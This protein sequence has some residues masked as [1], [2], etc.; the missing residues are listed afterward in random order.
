M[1]MP[2]ALLVL[3]LA[4]SPGLVVHGQDDT[5]GFI[6][7]DCGIAEGTAYA[8]QPTHGLRYVSDAGF[9]DAG[10]GLNAAINP[11]YNV[12]GTSTRY[13]T[14]R[15]FP[16]A[17]R[18]CYTLR[19]GVT[20]GG[21]YLVRATFYY[22]NY[23]GLNRLPVFD[24]HL[25]VNRWVTVNVTAPGA[26]YI[27][28]AVV[29]PPADFFQVCLVNRGL[30][31]PFISGL[32]LRPLQ[33]DMYP[34]ATLNQSLALLNFRRP[35][36]TYILNRYH[37][38]RPA[39]TYAL[40][41]YPFD[42]YDRLWQA[43]GDIDAW[44]NITRP[45]DVSNI[46]SFH[47]LP[48]ILWSAATPVNGTQI[49]FAWSS[50]SSINNDNTSYLLLLYFEEVQRLPSNAVRRFDILVDNSTWNGSQRYSP[51][52]LSSE[53]VKRMVLG[54]RQHTV[55][56]VATPDATLP[57]I[58][59][60]F[61]IYSV[62]PM[63]ELATNGA[64]AKAMMAIRTKYALKKNWMGD[65]CA[66]KA[67]AW[68]GL[69]C[70]NFSSG[71]AWITA[72][73]LSSSGLSGGIDASFGNLK[74][75]QWLDLSNNSLSGPVPDFL[76]QMPS[77]T[78]L[79]L[80]SNKL[81]GPVP[82]VLL[83][84]HQNG[85]LVLRIGN[86]ANI[87]DNGAST[88]EPE[89][90]NG[91]R[92]LA[93]A[94]VVPIAVATLLFVAALILHRLKHKQVTWTANNSRL[95][96]PQERSTAFGNRQFTYKE[97]KRMTA[98]FEE[99]I[100]RG[101]FGAVFLGYLENGSPVA[102]KMCTKTS[103]GDKAFSA[104]AQHLTRVHHRNLV[105]LI[106]YCKD[107]KHLALVY[108]YMQGGNLENRLR[109]QVSAITPLTWHQRLKIALDSAHGLEYLHKA[110]QP[111]LIHRDVK[112]TNILLSADLEAKISDFGL[113]KVFANDFDTHITTQPAGTL[114][115]LDPEYYNTSRLSE[116]SDVYSFGV[117]LLELIT[118]Q[119]PAVTITSTDRIHIALWVRQKL[120]M[121]N[122]ESIVDPRME[123]EYDVNSVWKVAELALQCKEQPSRERPTM[124][125]VVMELK[126]TLELDALHAMGYYSSVPS[127]TVNLS[128][129]SVDL[130]SDAQASEA[131]Q[132]TMLELEQVGNISET[133]IGPV[134]R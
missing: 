74:S 20:P 93:I 35:T 105:S 122:I 73:R 66:P 10:A 101:G 86:N 100:G 97:L 23:D 67:F 126:E 72:L 6:S 50:D 129:T 27:F 85:S 99:E 29:V 110:C 52:Y 25:G 107:K 31:T 119:P 108:E 111:P 4:V 15:Y 1:E 55:S 69:N 41:R 14:A 125:H 22:G 78:F 60:A 37:F 88:C 128:A 32:D 89:N 33:D 77:L 51:K 79:D 92:I 56:L 75:L 80:S 18:S 132:E 71:P 19:P 98:N 39:S 127:S 24:L 76:V 38:R 95:P 84:K 26:S 13:L 59:N 112:T 42:P 46:S 120:S 82:A 118:G 130:Q 58:L 113:T 115:Y 53:L 106:G 103:Q 131:R 28:E 102:I 30:G 7:I 44:T 48:M 12:E 134:A 36:A 90:K 45:V 8:D 65:P 68:D 94:I 54:S 43:Y 114:G 62:L 64:D 11:P 121:G 2:A 70:S 133:Q 124:T 21:R 16:D 87:C 49:D 104:E 47:T 57:P 5:L 34:E 123:G 17:R 117:V 9:T 91:K 116:K 63:T 61:E 96:S 40:L 81:S 109:G 83:Q 3:C